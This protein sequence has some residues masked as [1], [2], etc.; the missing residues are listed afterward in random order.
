[1]SLTIITY[2]FRLIHNDNDTVNNWI[3]MQ[4]IHDYVWASYTIYYCEEIN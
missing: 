2:Y 3:I 1:M 4:L